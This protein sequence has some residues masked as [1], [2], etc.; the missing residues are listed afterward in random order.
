MRNYQDIRYKNWR[1][2]IK[3]RDKFKCQWP[4]CVE[5]KTLH[6][7]HILPWSEYPGLRYH[8]NNGITLCKNHHNFIKNN[9]SSYASF[10]LKLLYAISLHHNK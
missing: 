7:H 10:F 5:K 3:V 4:G 8:I 1:K 6:V 2:Q 9:E